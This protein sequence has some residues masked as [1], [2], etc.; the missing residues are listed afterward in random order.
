MDKR[1][2]LLDS[3]GTQGSD[4]Q[5]YKVRAYEHLARDPSFGLEGEQWQSTG[6]I[7]YRLDDGR[8][9]DEQHDGTMTVHDSG[10]R[11]QR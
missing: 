9:V 6:E 1:L 3:F 8:R 11:L 2:H 10:V 7:E 5:T 4:G